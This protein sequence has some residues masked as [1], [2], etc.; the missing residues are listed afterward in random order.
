MRKIWGVFAFLVMTQPVYAG[1]EVHWIDKFDGTG[2]NYDIWTAQIQADYTGTQECYTDDETVGTG[3]LNVSNGTLKIIS[4]KGDINCP[5]LGGKAKTWTSGRLNTKDKAE[6]LYGRI[7]AK[8]KFSNLES[9]LWPA[10][11]AL[12]GRINEPP[13][14]G[15][16]D[17]VPWPN[18][19]AGE[20]DIWEWMA[21]IPGT[22]FTAFHN[23]EGDNASV[24]KCGKTK[25]I[26]L[27][28]GDSTIQDWHTYAMEWSKTSIKF[29]MDDTLVSTN[30]VSEC[31]QYKEPMFV[32]INI[33]MGGVGG[34]IDPTLTQATYELDYV[35]HCLST[36]SNNFSHC[37]EDTPVQV[38]DDGDGVRNQDDLCSSTPADTTTDIYGCGPEETAINVAPEV[39]LTLKQNGATVTGAINPA[40]GAVTITANISDINTQD[41]HSVNWSVGS[42]TGTTENGASLTFDPSAVAAG[43]YEVSIDV[44][45]N[46]SPTLSGS[47]II[48]FSVAEAATTGG[49]TSSG[50]GGGAIDWFILGF[51]L[52]VGY[53]RLLNPL[54]LK[55]R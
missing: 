45:D 34:P 17:N 49:K 23:A 12:E 32:L 38:D 55:T 25:K 18:P 37:N 28:G 36:E 15:D 20:I 9:G 14:A 44:T 2:V 48:S 26:T 7:E 40:K 19:G 50:G 11:W 8:L 16:G 46:G 33:Q 5:G 42:L 1:W 22:Y 43:N 29:Y 6:F 54:R 52:L 39:T 4:H 53:S 24:P 47:N 51:L 31:P 13:I 35:A 3:N 27:P 30:D 10:F 41:T 21:A